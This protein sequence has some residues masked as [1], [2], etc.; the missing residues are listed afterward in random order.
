MKFKTRPTLVEAFQYTSDLST[1]R[2]EL[3]FSVFDCK[4]LSISKNSIKP[5][6]QNLEVTEFKVIDSNGQ[7]TTLRCKYTDY[8]C[9]QNDFLVVKSQSE[10]ESDF[11]PV[12]PIMESLYKELN[13]AV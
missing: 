13:Q 10:F 9:H 11:E 3:L 1:Y 7:E 4:V 6:S 8:I 2:I 12:E 5:F